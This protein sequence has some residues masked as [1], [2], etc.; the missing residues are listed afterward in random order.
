M[1][2]QFQQITALIDD[3]VNTNDTS[4]PL[5]TKTRD[6]NLALDSFLA[7]AIQASGKFQ[8]DDSGHTHDPIITTDLTSGQRDYHWTKDEQDNIIL[9]VHRVMVANESGIFYDLDRVDQ[10]DSDDFKSLGIVDGQNLTGKPSAYDKTGNG[11]FLVPIPDYTYANGVKMFISREALYF[12]VADTTK[13]PGFA[14]IFHEYLALRPSYQYAYRK[15]LQSA[16]AL[17]TEMILMERKI[18]EWY[19]QRL[20]DER[21][22]LRN[23][24]FNY[25]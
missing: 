5:A 12:T 11:I 15:G 6:I 1:S 22:V 19:G 9:D 7:I 3:N 17:Q 14:G 10:Q 20:K 16:K 2:L 13:L 8:F 25:K 23:K 18:D 4:Y 21:P 24:Q